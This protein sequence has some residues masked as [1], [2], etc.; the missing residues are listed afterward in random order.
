M[1][2]VNKPIIIPKKLQVEGHNADTRNRRIYDL[3]PDS[4]KSGKSPITIENK[5]Y[6]HKTVKS[7]L[8]AAQHNKC[9][10]CE[11]D[12]KGENGNVEHFR[13][14][15]GYKSN[16]NEKKLK[17]PGYYWLGYDWSN[18]FFV[19]SACNSTGNKGNLFPLINE[20]KRAKSHHDDISQEESVLI[21]PS[22]PKDPRDHIYFESQ[23]LS[24]K[25]FIFIRGKTVFGK[26]TIE[27]CGLDREELNDKRAELIDNINARI[28]ILLKSGHF[29]VKEVEEARRFILNSQ[30]PES[31]F[32]ATAADYIKQLPIVIKI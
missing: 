24:G 3:D 7:V 5:I 20:S 32:S 6:G 25:S 1:I 14:K 16:K 31:K 23:F 12:Q 15:D 9:C 18:L 29:D 17:K 22:G 11:K 21:D 19:C 4:F 26:R 27:I 8:K 10:F 28:A 13:P 30:K 2:K